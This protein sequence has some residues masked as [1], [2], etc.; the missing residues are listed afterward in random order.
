MDIVNDGKI[1]VL[2]KFKEDV[3]EEHKSTFIAGLKE[4][5]KLPCVQSQQL[6]VG[7]PSITKEIEKSKGF[8]IALLSF[9][10]DR[11][12][13]DTYQASDEHHR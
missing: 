9:H 12:A 10:Q 7:S 5:R 6:V 1:V 3:S 11:E 13:L 4:L 2:F 8:Q